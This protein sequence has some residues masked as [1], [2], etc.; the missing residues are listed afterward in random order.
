[1]TTDLELDLRQWL[2]SIP[3]S[4]EQLRQL[5]TVELPA[6][7]GAT[8]L[9]RWALAA[10][11]LVVLVGVAALAISRAPSVG[12]SVTAG[13][14]IL[15]DGPVMIRTLPQIPVCDAARETRTLVADPTYGLALRHSGTTYGAIWPYGY[16]ARRASGVTFLVAPSGAVVA[17]EGDQIAAAGAA[18]TDGTVL[19]ECDVQVNGVQVNAATPIPPARLP[20]TLIPSCSNSNSSAPALVGI[21]DLRPEH[22]TLLANGPG[23]AGYP[24]TQ[25]QAYGLGGATVPPR[26]GPGRLALYETFSARDPFF[27]SRVDQLRNAGATS[28]PATVCG[29]Q[30][31]VWVDQTTG[32]LLVG[33]TDRGKTDVLVANT[34]DFTVQQLI[35]SAERVNDCCG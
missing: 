22:W 26:E 11:A 12:P 28:T 10:A 25:W 5:R 30:T 7:P 31:E 14:T 9:V 21:V 13:P 23:V 33:W 35:D 1:M 16:S 3:V 27:V 4:D 8:R 18:G 32:E 2:A 6:R 34:A 24:E 29:V 17:R 20:P 19:L 15:P